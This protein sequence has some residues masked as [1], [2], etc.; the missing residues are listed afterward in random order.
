MTH[1]PFRRTLLL[2]GVALP[3]AS[4]TSRIWAADTPSELLTQELGRLETS[5]KGRLGLALINTGTGQE[6]QYRGDERFPFCSTFKLMLASAVLK[7]SMTQSGLLTQHITYGEDDLLS[8]API[9]RKNLAHGMSVSELCVAALQYSDNTAANLLIKQIGGLEAV[10][11]FAQSLGDPDFR[12]DRIEPDLNSALPFDIRDTTTPKA[13]ANSLK[14]IALGSSI[15]APNL[16]AQLITWIKGNTTGDATIRAGVPSGWTVGDKTG[17]GNYGTTNDIGLLWPPSGEPVVL[18]IYFTQLKK[19]ADNRR[20]VL[21][22][23]TKL[24]LAH[25]PDYS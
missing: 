16:R 14:K 3:F 12:L 22:A 18:T 15:L 19:D 23:A 20:D 1:S 5:S 9:T 7:K 10:N 25:Y 13:M 24:A 8:Y 2:A 6:F 4:F 17:S 11:H 21:A